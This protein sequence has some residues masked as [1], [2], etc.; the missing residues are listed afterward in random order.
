[1]TA[2]D[3]RLQPE[4]IPRRNWMIYCH[5]VMDLGRLLHSCGRGQVL[6]SSRAVSQREK[7]AS[8]R[9]ACRAWRNPEPDSL[10][11]YQ[12]SSELWPKIGV[13]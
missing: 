7:S 6:S 2:A 13:E 10:N 4:L 12:D 8:G 1:M 11:F 9:L 5:S 3:L